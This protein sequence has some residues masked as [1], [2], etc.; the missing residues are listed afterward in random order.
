MRHS[1]M[2]VLINADEGGVVDFTAP[3]ARTGKSLLVDLINVLATGRPMPVIS[4][5]PAI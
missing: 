5:L 1:G 3:A 4:Q 2:L